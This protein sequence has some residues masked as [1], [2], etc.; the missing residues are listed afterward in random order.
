MGKKIVAILLILMISIS[1]LPMAIVEELEGAFVSSAR[2]EFW[3]YDYKGY[4]ETWTA[5]YTGWYQINCYGAQ[6]GECATKKG[7]Y[8]TGSGKGVLRAS[9]VKI[10]KGTSLSIHV[11]GLKMKPMEEREDG[12]MEQQE[13]NISNNGKK[14]VKCME[15]L[16]VV[17]AEA[18]TSP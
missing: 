12:M 4:N 8:N 18:H 11:G 14:K 15:V 3:G 6:G 13:K 5:P 10:K 1:S 2:T 9:I 17:V 16:V 7:N